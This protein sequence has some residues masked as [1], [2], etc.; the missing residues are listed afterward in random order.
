MK[1][2]IGNIYVLYFDP[3]DL[4][5]FHYQSAQGEGISLIC[6]ITA[7]ILIVMSCKDVG[8]DSTCKRY[9]F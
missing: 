3:K 4:G 1:S 8:S 2:L 7:Q 6:G 5:H 9:A